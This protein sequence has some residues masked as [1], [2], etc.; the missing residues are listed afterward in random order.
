[1]RDDAV[2]AFLAGRRSARPA[3]LTEPGP[4]AAQL[5]DILTIAARVPDHKKLAPWRFIVFAGAAR[6]AFGERLA[7]AVANDPD[8]DASDVRLETERTRLLRAPV[9]VA[10][11]SSPRALD[12]VPLIEQTLSCGA[13]AFALCLAAN[14]HGFATA[15]I[16]EW[17]SYNDDVRGAMGLA[18]DEQVAGFVYIGSQEAP[19]ADRD[20]PDIDAI[21]TWWS[22]TDAS[23]V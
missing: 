5:S 17:V 18:A 15:W 4:D 16:T 1:M 20:R 23:S 12:K 7:E 11:V 2:L 13:C 8:I 9:V 21:T 6:A 22:P 3:H 19:Q 10:V 14:A